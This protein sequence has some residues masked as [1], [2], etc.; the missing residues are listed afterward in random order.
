MDSLQKVSTADVPAIVKQLS[1]FR[2][3]AD[4]Q[5]ERV[6]Q[7]ID[8]REHLHAS[9][10][11]LPVDATQV[12][13]LFNRLLTASASEL[14]VLRD[15]LNP[16]R[17][18]LTPKLWTA[19]E[20]AKPGDATL[21]P[22]ASALARYDPDNAEWETIGGKV[23]QT[24]VTINSIYLGP[25]L[26]ALRPVHGRLTAPITTIFQ[27]KSSETVHSLATDILTDYASDDP[28]RLA[29]VLMV[30]DPKAYLSLF[31]V[32][33]KRAEQVL[34]VF[35]AELAKKATYSWNDPLLDPTW[36]KPDTTLVSGIEAAQGI[37]AERF[38]FC[39]T[40][41]MDEF[42]TTA[43]A[44][45]KSGY[46]PVRFRPDSDEKTVRVAAVWTRDGR[47]CRISSG[48]T[49]DEVR[50]QDE[51][52]KKHNFLPVDVAGC[53]TTD[54][55]G[56]PA[57]RYAALWVERSGEDDARFY[58]G[59]TADEATAVQDRLKE[60]KLIPRTLHAMIG[61][62]GRTRCCGVWGRPPGTS[63]TGR[64]YRDQFEGTLERDTRNPYRTERLLIEIVVS[65][66]GKSRSIRDRL[67][68][69]LVSADKKL[70]TEPDDLDSRLARPAFRS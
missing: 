59:T 28:D 45:R 13:Y 43:E 15:A 21:L 49:A 38:A 46:R 39:Q 44:L 11:L 53:V 5:L 55:G 19:L 57:D 58:V 8:D 25:W 37:L 18:S 10:A 63:I 70:K 68:A 29:E 17:S 61:S 54:T 4:P 30:S 1:G 42:L 51:R 62:E 16:H 22:S 50:Q 48:L 7:S 14:P 34:P 35:Q 20:S 56:N 2:R 47:N 23:A 41:P 24:L 40:M 9:L 36:T 66:A 60:A 26:E 32:A 64:T 3:W 65:G 69:A 33:E 67:Q 12:D 31:P 6:V 27:D 52:N